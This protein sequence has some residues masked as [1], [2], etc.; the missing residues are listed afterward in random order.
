MIFFPIFQRVQR[1]FLVALMEAG[2]HQFAKELKVQTEQYL[3]LRRQNHCR[4]LQ[5]HSLRYQIPEFFLPGRLDGRSHS[6]RRYIEYGSH[7]ADLTV[8]L[9]PVVDSV[10]TS[11]SDVTELSITVSDLSQSIKGSCFPATSL[12]PRTVAVAPTQ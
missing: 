10:A 9:V 11:G 12:V 4:C 1:C 2:F 8:R 3:C 7:T 5:E 6:D